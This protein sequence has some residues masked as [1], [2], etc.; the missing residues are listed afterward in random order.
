M[1]IWAD[2]SPQLDELAQQHVHDV[3]FF[4]RDIGMVNSHGCQIPQN[5]DDTFRIEAADVVNDTLVQFLE[6]LLRGQCTSLCDNQQSSLSCDCIKLPNPFLDAM[7]Q[8][9]LAP[10]GEKKLVVLVSHLR[11][12]ISLFPWYPFLALR[13]RMPFTIVLAI[14]IPHCLVGMPKPQ[15]HQ[16]HRATTP[17]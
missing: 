17:T 12:A 1:V 3:R 11:T 13:K 4:S 6:E 15:S 8:L 16:D 14:R 7:Q 5:L 10:C 9:F 2:V